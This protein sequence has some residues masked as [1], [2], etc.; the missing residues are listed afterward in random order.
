MWLR[1]QRMP[2][3]CPDRALA[4]KRGCS[5]P[6]SLMT[7]PEA[8]QHHVAWS[9]RAWGASGWVSRCCGHSGQVAGRPAAASSSISHSCSWSAR[10]AS[11]SGAGRLSWTRMPREPAPPGVWI[12]AHTQ[13]GPRSS[14]ASSR[15][16]GTIAPLLRMSRRT[17]SRF[18]RSSA[19]SASV[20]ARGFWAS[21]HE[22][23][24]AWAPRARCPA[25][26]RRSVPLRYRRT[27]RR[28]NLVA[29]HE[30]RP[31]LAG[32]LDAL[33]AQVTLPGR[34]ATTLRTPGGP[35]SAPDGWKLVASRRH[36]SAA[37]SGP[38]RASGFLSA[39]YS[40]AAK[41]PWDGWDRI[42]SHRHPVPG[43]AVSHERTCTG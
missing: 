17:G 3:A 25:R 27:R 14:C 35:G 7:C 4:V 2:R 34:A 31:A 23:R 12:Q 18:A 30:S 11:R 41:R 6:M 36:A 5:A 15:M 43:V 28:V 21:R 1:A 32:R 38:M 9:P 29:R 26:S 37:G 24:A 13:S 42:W 22:R 40:H 39:S 16:P 8:G 20:S 10:S 19:R 33:K